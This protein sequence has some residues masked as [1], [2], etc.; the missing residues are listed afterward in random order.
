MLEE[1]L[2]RLRGHRNNIHRYRRLLRTRLT[3]TERA[4]IARRLDEEQAAL[5]KLSSETF[6]LT[7][8]LPAGP[9]ATGEAS[10]A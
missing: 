2:A 3:D 7:F 6:P 9:P 10:H 4:F 5:K 1:T 8:S